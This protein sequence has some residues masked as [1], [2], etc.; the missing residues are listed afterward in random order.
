[1]FKQKFVNKKD[2]NL[3]FLNNLNKQLSPKGYFPSVLR[4]S[5]K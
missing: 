2:E 1:M 3:K 4:A 5:R